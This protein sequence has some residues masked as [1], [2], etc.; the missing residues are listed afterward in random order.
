MA[1]THQA[2]PVAASR[3]A[4]TRSDTA[5][6]H[7]GELTSGGHAGE[8]V[9]VAEQLGQQGALRAEHRLD[10]DADADAHHQQHEPDLTEGEQPEAGKANT[11]V[12]SAPQR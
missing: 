5:G 7:R 8:P 10:A 4:P 1:I 11:A 6:D 12:N 3:A 9:G 2:L